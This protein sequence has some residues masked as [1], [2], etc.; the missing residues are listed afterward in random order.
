MNNWFS[1]LHHFFTA[2]VASVGI[3]VA[4]VFHQPVHHAIPTP[5]TAQIT[6]SVSPTITAGDGP[7]ISVIP[8]QTPTITKSAQNITVQKTISTAG[9]K[10]TIFLSIPKNGGKIDGSVS[11]DCQG[12]IDGTY[13][14]PAFTGKGEITC[15]VG[16][17]SLPATAS[18]NGVVHPNKQTID[19]NYSVTSGS[20]F[21]KSGSITVPYM[22]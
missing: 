11:G 19:I 13:T 10:V 22:Q 2:G 17:L 9:K 15:T 20:N 18:F 3:I 6:A 21:S 14:V 1:A 8:T 16:F 4:S 12:A 7:T 5:T